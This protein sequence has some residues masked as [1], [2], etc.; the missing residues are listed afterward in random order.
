MVAEHGGPEAVRRL[1][2]GND[3]SDGFTT[4]WEAHRL[5]TSVEAMVLLPWY[6][7]LFTDDER[8]TA[9]R[10]LTEHGFDVEGL[11]QSRSAHPPAWG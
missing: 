3:M 4:L 9:R 2:Q 10:R 6:A 7:H 8:E 5:K 11:L 1:L